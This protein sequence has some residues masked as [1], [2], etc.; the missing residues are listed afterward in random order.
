MR[1]TPEEQRATYLADLDRSFNRAGVVGLLLLICGR[2]GSQ[3]TDLG[4]MKSA[5]ERCHG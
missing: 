2:R 3:L 1:M 5:T 4:P